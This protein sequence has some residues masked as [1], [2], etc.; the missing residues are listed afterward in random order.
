MLFL[1]G[2]VDILKIFCRNHF[3]NNMWFGY[4][5]LNY[6]LNPG[7]FYHKLTEI[8]L[9]LNCAYIACYHCFDKKFIL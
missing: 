4:V 9:I 3:K 2:L 5:F 7:L 1:V 8:N 6:L